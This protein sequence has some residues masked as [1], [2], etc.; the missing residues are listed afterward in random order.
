MG[1]KIVLS[2]VL[3]NTVYV[4][5]CMLHL[6]HVLYG[7]FTCVA[8]EKFVVLNAADKRDFFYFLWAG[9]RL[10]LHKD[11]QDFQNWYCLV[12]VTEIRACPATVSNSEK[13]W[14]CLQISNYNYI[15]A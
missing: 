8:N 7:L 10:I 9:L 4:Y 13:E 15:S 14:L 5:V 1:K 2:S 6:K 12:I 3:L 11:I